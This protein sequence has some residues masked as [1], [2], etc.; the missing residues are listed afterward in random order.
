MS[1]NKV[2][3]INKNPDLASIDDEI[4]AIEYDLRQIM[5][6]AE[7]MTRYN[8]HGQLLQLEAIRRHCGQILTRCL[9]VDQISKGQHVPK[10]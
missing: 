9:R 6:S 7:S 5:Q 8:E 4:K 3:Y 10:T 1:D 2:A